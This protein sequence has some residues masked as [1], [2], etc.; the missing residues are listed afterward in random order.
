MT[1]VKDNKLY[2]VITSWCPYCK[3]SL[4]WMEELMTENEE[5]KDLEIE[6]IDEE[7]SPTLASKYTYELV[8]NFHLNGE[9]IYEGAATRSDIE[10]VMKKTYEAQKK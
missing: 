6:V 3:K 2:M 4:M 10:E 9:K 5:Y 8:P 7:V 1:E